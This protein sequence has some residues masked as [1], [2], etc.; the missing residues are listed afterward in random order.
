VVVRDEIR[1]SPSAVAVSLEPIVAYFSMEIALE[2]QM[3]TY[4]GG[5]GVLAGDTLRSA[6]DLEVPMAAVTLLHRHGYFEQ[7]LDA[8]GRQQEAPV[9]W[10]IE[11]FLEPL[12]ARVAIE[13][14]GRR[15]ALTCWRRRVRGI[16][17]F[18]IPVY[19]LDADL[20]ENDAG[21]RRLTDSLYGGDEE[22][23]LCQEVVLGL[24][25]IALLR[26]LGHAG[27]ERYHLNEGHAA[28]IVLAL[29]EERLAAS[30]QAATSRELLDAVRDACVF[31]TH[32]PV[33]AGHDQFAPELVERVLGSQRARR[34]EAFT[35]Q[36]Q[37]NMTDLALR[38]SGYVN[39]VAMSHWEVSR[40]L[41]PDY[42]VH[43]ITNGVHVRTWAS[44]PFQ[45]LFD[46]WLPDWRR[47]CLSLRYAIRIPCH[48]IWRAHVA[49]KRALVERVNREGQALFDPEVLTLGFARRATAYKRM[50][51]VFADLERLRKLCDEHGR[52]QLVFAGKA[53]PRDEA[54][55]QLILAL[56]EIRDALRGRVPIAYLP[57]HDL[58][59]GRLLCAG[60]DVWLNT[61]LPPLEASGTSGMKAAVN[62]VP[63]LSTLDG[64]FV[65]GHI[66]G[67]TGWSIGDEPCSREAL[68]AEGDAADARA[69]YD[70]L[71]RAVLPCFYR[72]P[73]A[74]HRVM[75]STIAINASFYNSDRMLAQYLHS[76]YRIGLAPRPLRETTA[77]R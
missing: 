76:A 40:D 7:R 35:G 15:V 9:A 27:I 54:G 1:S 11:D 59:V 20:P 18:E 70:K 68:H 44:A 57:N 61:P 72:T 73:E 56:H 66:E 52:L 5:L 10:R 16:S 37:L 26:A 75:R 22:Y 13:L 39:G 14:C 6:A 60:S 77:A 43:A 2:S 64:W 12:D 25:G 23:R 42:K 63:S 46:R 49:A 51:L 17:D 28:L 45:A 48:E 50:T 32:T 74:F 58:E 8:A 65:E 67:H 55:K 33:P 69:L 29:F 41:Y 34:L 3:P 30:G 36:R 62:G 53:H 71:E 31:T 4:A 21:D 47:D 24:G 19:L 38:G